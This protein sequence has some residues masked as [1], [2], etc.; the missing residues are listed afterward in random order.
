MPT[1][2]AS[3]AVTL[4]ALEAKGLVP[5]GTAPPA[6]ARRPAKAPPLVAGSAAS[7][8][9]PAWAEL[10]VPYRLESRA[11]VDAHRHW[12]ARQR[13]A[14]AL[15]ALLGGMLA[16]EVPSAVRAR[17]ALG[18]VVRITRIAPRRLDKAD[19][20]RM[21]CKG[22]ADCVAQALLGGRV[23]QMDDDPALDFRYGQEADGPRYGVRVRLWEAGRRT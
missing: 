14:K 17:L 18:C 3:V 1:T 4:A 23:G 9:A 2:R 19:N 8:L 22:A 13:A 20:L 12:R 10:V 21:A 5:P 16:Y 7:G 15:H 6:K 11:N